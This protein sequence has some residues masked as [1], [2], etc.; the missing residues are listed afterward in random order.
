MADEY[1]NTGQF[2]LPNTMSYAKPGQEL[3]G[4]LNYHEFSP[5]G[6]T[7][8]TPGDTIEIDLNSTNEW[9]DPK[10]CYL[11]FKLVF[12][13]GADTTTSKLLS[14]GYAGIIDSIE[15]LV[16]GVQVEY[17]DQYSKYLSWLYRRLP[18]EAQETL[19]KIENFN[20]A[21][22]NTYALHTGYTVGDVVCHSLRTA[23]WE[24]SK[25]IPLM[26]CPGGIKLRI[27]L[28]DSVDKILSVKNS[29]TTFT[30]S[31]IR[32]VC[33]MKKHSDQINSQ[34][35]ENLMN[36]GVINIPLEKVKYIRNN[37]DQNGNTNAVEH[38][39]VGFVKSVNSV[40][41]LTK[42]NVDGVTAV[43][44]GNGDSS[45]Q[46]SLN[47]LSSYHVEIGSQQFPR[48]FN[49]GCGLDTS[50]SAFYNTNPEIYIQQLVSLDNTY[51]FMNQDGNSNGNQALFY[52]FA[53]S[54]SFGVGLPASDGIISLV[55][56][57]SAAPTASYV[58]E[59]FV[60]YN[61]LLKITNSQT[62]LDEKYLV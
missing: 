30:V 26:F 15:T 12:S 59:N 23:L 17:F 24:Q 33:G 36:G 60:F 11:K 58:Q 55:K 34:M 16:N 57:Y 32:M 19:K 5:L 29:T 42:A 52:N 9:I 54:Q 39:N 6:A 51:S 47:N 40:Y 37:P 62:I 13:G 25:E 41:Q 46:W 20:T 38:L 56:N 18:S 10:K 14:V 44:T 45:N 21:P 35:A 3:N 49:I 61:A 53:P 27:K 28:K 8:Y 50:G 43:T 48:N 2:F 7:S 4:V 22:T 1:K 31:N